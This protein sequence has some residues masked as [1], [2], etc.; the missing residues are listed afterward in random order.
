MFTKATQLVSQLVSLH[1]AL[2]RK[3]LSHLVVISSVALIAQ[4]AVN[5]AIAQE[6]SVDWKEYAFSKLPSGNVGE[7]Y[8]DGDIRRSPDG[9]NVK[10]WVKAL[11]EK[12]LDRAKDTMSKVN[13]GRVA[14]K[15]A[16]YYIPPI[17]TV[18]TLTHD[19]LYDTVMN[20]QVADEAEI[21]PRIR[22][23]Y[24]LDCAGRLNREISMHINNKGH[25]SSTDTTSEWKHAAPETP[26]AT[27]QA[28]LCQIPVSYK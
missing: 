14:S 11:D 18:Q 6:T 13:I 19:Q 12:E 26:M 27:L 1:V 16:H 17:S 23:L 25:I 4:L 21:Q 2:V 7:F 8:S 24:E 10:V 28:L 20:E 3:R 9:H 5:V 15:I 22:V